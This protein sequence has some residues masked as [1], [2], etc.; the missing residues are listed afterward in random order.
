M[1]D[2]AL[3]KYGLLQKTAP[4]P[5]TVPTPPD[6]DD[7][8]DAL[9]SYHDAIRAIAERVKAGEPVPDCLLPP[10]HTKEPPTKRALRALLSD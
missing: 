9:A 8:A 2:P 7:L 1:S 10:S 3:L 5:T 4:C 6:F